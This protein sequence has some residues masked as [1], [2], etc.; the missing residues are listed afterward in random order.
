MEGKAARRRRRPTKC[1][2]LFVRNRPID[3]T[4]FTRERFYRG[5]NAVEHFPFWLLEDENITRDKLATPKPMKMKPQDWIDFK[6]AEK[7]HV[8][9]GHLAKKEHKNIMPIFD[10]NIGKYQGKTHGKCSW[11]SSNHLIQKEHTENF[12]LEEMEEPEEG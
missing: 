2:G 4:A 7:C 9:D 6:Q 5:K 10:P 8:C 1:A 12:G 3:G 11:E